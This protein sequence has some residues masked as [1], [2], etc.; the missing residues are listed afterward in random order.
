[1][2]IRSELTEQRVYEIKQVAGGWQWHL[3][4]RYNRSSKTFT[5]RMDCIKD[6]KADY[7]RL[8]E[9]TATQSGR[10]GRKIYHI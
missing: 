5:S 8:R 4:W 10:R 7:A 3:V 1:M 6:A 9:E 2:E